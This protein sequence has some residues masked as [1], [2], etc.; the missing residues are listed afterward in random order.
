M[1]R[2]FFR[3]IAAGAFASVA[4]VTSAPVASAPPDAPERA[5]FTAFLDKVRQAHVEYVQSR[6][7]A[8][9]ALWSRTPDV[10]IFGGF[11]SGERGWDKVGPRL[12]WASAQFSEGSRS[13]ETITSSVD[14]NL[15]YLVQLEKVRF[16]IPG[17]SEESLLE[18]RA[19][20]IFR[21]EPEGWRIVHRHAD[22]QM[23]RQGPR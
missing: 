22:S 7:A 2:R 16:K 21:R 8:F 13:Y 6:P 3:L 5:E 15:G 20:M 17:R 19:T 1:A 23:T 12:D 10:T 9:K 14:G 11:G 4:A 18:L